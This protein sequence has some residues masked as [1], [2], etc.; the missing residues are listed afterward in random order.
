[1][2]VAPNEPFSLNPLR[3]DT[4]MVDAVNVI[5]R[6]AVSFLP[7]DAVVETTCVV[8]AAGALP[9]VAGTV[10]YALQGMVRCAYD[11]SKLSVDA[12]LSGDRRM[13]LQAAMAHPA[14]RDLDAIEAVIEEMFAAQEKREQGGVAAS[15]PLATSA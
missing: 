2:A 8:G 11:A 14:H 1:M 10:P 4:G 13:V 3:D 6:G 15:R 5:N 7:D 9:C 12:A